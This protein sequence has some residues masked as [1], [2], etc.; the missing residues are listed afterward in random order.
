M[1][2]KVRELLVLAEAA[3]IEAQQA[4]QAAEAK[5]Q[6]AAKERDHRHNVYVHTSN[7]VNSIKHFLSPPPEVPY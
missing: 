3:M 7:M 1:E 6:E 5:V 2:E 4:Y